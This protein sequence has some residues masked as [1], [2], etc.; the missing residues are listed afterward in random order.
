MAEPVGED[1]QLKFSF[2]YDPGY[3]IVAA[4][5]VWAGVTARGDIQL[6]FF[7]ESHGVPAEVVNLIT[8][9][10]SLG[11]ELTRSPAERKFVRRVQVGILLS[12][13]QADDIADFIKA[14]VAEFRNL[15]QRRQGG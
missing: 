11:P 4:N 10:G 5:G 3:R 14:K 2:E 12:I 6:D 7:V 9:E 13:G 1:R 15:Q 8:P